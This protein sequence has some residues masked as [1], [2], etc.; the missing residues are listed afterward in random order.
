MEPFRELLKPAQK[1]RKIYWDDNLT[2]LFEESKQVIIAAIADG[3]KSFKTGEW[4]CLMPDACKTGIGYLLSQKRCKC[5]E[6]NPYCCTG[7]WQTVLAG[8]RFTKDAETRYAPVELESLAI[9][10]GLENT[11]HYTLGNQKLIVATDHK[12]LEKVMGDR[13]LEDIN[14]PRLLKLKERTLMWNFDIIHV[15]GKIHIGPDTLS[16]KEVVN[17]VINIDATETG[18]WNTDNMEA[19]LEATVAAAV[20]SPIT[21]QQIREAV[22]TD[23]ESS[24]LCDQINSGFPPDRK[25]LRLELR[26]Y[27]RHKENLTQVDGVPLYKDR[28]IIPRSL[29]PAVLETLHSA[30]QGVT[31]MNLRAQSSVWWPGITAQIKET[32]DKCRNCAEY[33]PSQPSAPPLPLEEPDHPFQRICTDYM[34]YA[35][36][37]YLIIVDRFSGWPSVQ[38]C[39]DST[40]SAD[41]LIKMLREFFANH[42]IPEEISSDGGLTYMAYE[43]QKFLQ[44]YGVHHRVSSVAFPHSNQRAELGCKSIKRMIR[45]NT[46]PGGTLNSDKFLRAVMTYRNTA[47][48][49]IGLSP[50]QIIFGRN[51]RDFMPS[52][53]LRLKVAPEW[54]ITIKERENSL[55]KRAIRNTEK[56]A[57]GTKYL[58]PL[59]VGDWVSVQNQTGNFP[60]R[61]DTTAEVVEVRPH[62]QYVV[63]THGSGR[64]TVRNRKFLRKI[65]RLL[66]GSGFLPMPVTPPH[67]PASEEQTVDNSDTTVTPSGVSRNPVT[68]SGV[69]RNP[70]TPPGVSRNPPVEGPPDTEISVNQEPDEH[71]QISQENLP[72]TREPVEVS[73]TPSPVL[74]PVPRRSRRETKQPDRLNISKDGQKSQ[75]YSTMIFYN[76]NATG[77]VP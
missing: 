71:E 23:K 74:S 21:W 44:D 34:Q 31:G 58:V 10:W 68:P 1:G 8:S 7:G 61:W 3:I 57:I 76:R 77:S 38:H 5:E 22:N 35:G 12:P 26:E 62:D 27:Q 54:R 20:V 59:K 15:P 53:L 13:Q 11:K 6:I 73:E 9:A 17:A 69:S 2:K 75:S 4:T 64:F 28:V 39:G 19:E 37:H 47:D 63:K 55:R 66:P 42:G 33:A 45:E 51:L 50:A 14:N 32:R 25:L 65:N 60:T 46:G 41:K 48:R 36:Q 24:M 49:D 40:G 16:R 56:L 72:E 67:I 18:D 43:T 70:V 30:H 52:P 29:R